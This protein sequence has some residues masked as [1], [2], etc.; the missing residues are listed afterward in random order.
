M[1]PADII[2]FYN[3][4]INCLSEAAKECIP[5]GKG[6][7]HNVMPGWNDVVS[8]KHKESRDAFHLWCSNGKPRQGPIFDM[9]KRCR[10][11]FK[12]AVRQCRRLELQNRA[13]GMAKDLLQNDVKSFWKKVRN[14]N[15]SK[16]TLATCVDRQS[17]EENIANMWQ[18][19]YKSL[20]NSVNNE[21]FK[22][23]V[24]KDVSEIVVSD[25]M[26]VRAEEV[27]MICNK[28]EPGKSAGP[29]N[30]PNEA[31]KHCNEKAYVL[32]AMCFTT[33]FIHGFLPNNMIRSEIVP[34]V[35][36]K[37]GNLADKNNY[38]PVA[39]AN[40]S[41]KLLEMVMLSRLEEYLWTTDNQF[42]FKKNLSTDLCIYTL[43]ECIE[44]YKSRNTT[45]FVTFLDASKAFDRLH[46]W[47]LFRK[48]CKRGAKAYLVR[49]IM[50][51][52]RSQEMHVRW[53]RTLS[54]PFNVSNGIKQGGILS[55]LLFNIYM[56]DLSLVLNKTNIGGK[57]GDYL[58]NHLLYADDVVLIALSSRGMQSLLNACQEYADSH[59]LVFNSIK[60][61]VWF[62][63]RKV[64]S[65]TIHVLNLMVQF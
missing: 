24:I 54:D 1:P 40:I 64:S 16:A 34:L 63:N 36:N 57:I 6:S 5:S 28:L 21:K 31:L 10:A 14:V 29:D 59:N 25:D 61:N 47:T 18:S 38:R 56:N 3:D 2:Q 8:D 43:R 7:N 60:H 26:Y 49:I 33:C 65:S 19:H 23:D 20:L 32:L 11:Q 12:Y 4:I 13:D 15:N 22:D 58:L 37:C 39:L 55:P 44:F 45:I 46:H 48:L 52:Y 62:L 51:W 42:G 27:R 35:K 50:Y 9:M 53:G 30:L 17:G 41:S